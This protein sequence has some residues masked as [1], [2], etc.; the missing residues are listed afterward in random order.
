MYKAKIAG[1][2]YYLP[3]NEVD[4]HELAEIMD[5]TDEWVQ[6][7]TGIQ[8]RRYAKKHEETSTTMGTKAALIAIERAGINKEDVDFIVF[9]TLSP[10][11]Y[12][13]G[14]GVLLQRELGITKTEIGAIDI[15]NQCSARPGPISPFDLWWLLRSR[16]AA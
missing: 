14:C 4:N 8:K 3:E 5:T 7:R 15:R 13:P 2:G 1:L 11:Y 12:F 10:D 16:N 6:E 9:A